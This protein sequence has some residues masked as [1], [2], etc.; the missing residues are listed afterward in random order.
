MDRRAVRVPRG[1]IGMSSRS[2]A[3][4]CRL[5]ARK[6]LKSRLPALVIVAAAAIWVYLPSLG[7]SNTW[8]DP[9]LLVSSGVDG[10]TLAACFTGSFLS[11]YYRPIVAASFWMDRQ[12]SMSH[13]QW[14]VSWWYSCMLRG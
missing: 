11:L 5:A 8:E 10:S 2:L 3:G 6:I 12:W 13:T 4:L 9:F 7:N 1:E 14:E